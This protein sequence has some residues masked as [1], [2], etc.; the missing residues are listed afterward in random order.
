MAF[1]ILSAGTVTRSKMRTL[2]VKA[3][4][5][6]VLASM[7]LVLAGGF[8]LGYK[9]SRNAASFQFAPHADDGSGDVRGA[10][11]ATADD[12]PAAE[13]GDST[14][15]AS[16]SEVAALAASEPVTV[17]PAENRF[18]I[19]RFGELSGRMIQL[20]AEAME[21]SARIG[22]IQEFEA[23]I[24]TDEIEAEPEGRVARTPPGAPA[25]GP[26][27]RPV[28][29]SR[30]AAPTS[31]R[32]FE[33]GD[34]DISPEL[35]TKELERMEGEAERLSE[36]LARLDRIATSYNLAHMSFPGRQPVLDV[37]IASSFGN[38]LDPFTKR[39]AF[40]SGVDY[41]APRGTPIYASAGGR[42]IFA[43]RRSHYGN[44]VEIDHG[45]GLV[46]RYAHASKLLVE[47][48]QVVMPGDAIALVGSTGR[49]TGPHL[50]FEILKDGRF[51]DPSIYL[52]R[53]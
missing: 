3:F 50:H 32:M 47:S 2:S 44:T 7:L 34:D 40:H 28:A 36:V 9:F 19:D 48:D 43:G 17:A 10:V 30:G 20:E 41:P 4:V 27:L 1:V 51:V 6:L 31:L 24:K 12:D 49:S 26:L 18:L 45:G 39:R 5:G 11:A 13:V 42:V 29:P 23:R 53:F 25:G 52:A 8:A 37:A 35:L 38:R 33:L 16:S 22:A 21:L 15:L 46:T 14:E